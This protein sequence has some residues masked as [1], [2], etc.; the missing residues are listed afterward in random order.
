MVTIRDIDLDNVTGYLGNK[1]FQIAAAYDLAKKN[2]DELVLP[3][4]EFE[5]IFENP[6]FRTVDKSELK[7]DNEYSEPFFHYQEIPYKPNLNL[8]GY[9]QSWKYLEDISVLNLNDKMQDSMMDKMVPGLGMGWG[10]LLYFGTDYVT[11]SI[12]VRR[13]DYINMSSHHPTMSID[14]YNRAIEMLPDVDYFVI[15][16]NDIEW[17][18]EN[19]KGKKFIFSD[20]KQEKMQGNSAAVF[21]LC[22]MS[23]CDHH[24]VANSSFSWWAAHLDQSWY[25]TVICPKNWFGP[26]LAHHNTNDLFPENWIKI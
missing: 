26:A 5:N 12:H 18:K 10:D 7:I 3:H 23:H 16:S 15:C 17:C 22:I 13:G 20:S 24:I 8:V 6:F 2:G 21:D 25:K 19:F 14:Y 9:F 1:L 4:F 11:C